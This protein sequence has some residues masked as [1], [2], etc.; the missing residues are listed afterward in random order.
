MAKQIIIKGTPVVAANE[1][2]VADSNSKIPAVDGSAVTTMAGGNIT[3]TIPT[4][5]LDTGT[6][7]NKVV[8]LGASG[9]PAV[10]GSL[11]TGIVSY[12]K[13]ASDPTVSTNPATGVGTEWVNH[14][15]GKQYICTDATADANVWK[16]SGGGTGD[17]SPYSY[18]GSD[19]G[20]IL[21][22]HGIDKLSF[23]SGGNATEHGNMATGINSTGRAGCSG[24]S[25][26][27]H[28]YACGGYG[29]GSY[30]PNT[31]DTIERYLFSA[32]GTMV[33]VGNMIIHMRDYATSN[34]ATHGFAQGGY[35]AANDPSG[36]AVVGYDHIQQLQFAATNN[37]TDVANLTSILGRPVGHSDAGNDY[38]YISGG[39]SSPQQT[40][41]QRHSMTS[42]SDSVN[43]GNLNQASPATG[44]S[45]A[46]HGYGAGQYQSGTS[47]EIQKFAFSSS[48]TTSDHGDIASWS[49]QSTGFSSTDDGYLAGGGIPSPATETSN[50]IW[51]YSFS[52]SGNSTD[53]GDL[54][55]TQGYLG[56][57]SCQV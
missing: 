50:I 9:L 12:T 21:N 31:S 28:A 18:G 15:T 20:H 57:N 48:T 7:A 34:N 2:L 51:K 55:V 38:A 10:D 24:F 3:G 43:V 54:T 36:P 6:T 8:V 32:G 4:A 33:D 23:A 25:S 5:R 41:I 17:V 46:T 11:L 40:T 44:T 35:R 16:A 37:A 29:P 30:T 56:P 42:A 53:V 14:T 19:S 47:T 1:V 49:F 27:T 39:N 45:S 52:S 26:L 13:S 22:Q